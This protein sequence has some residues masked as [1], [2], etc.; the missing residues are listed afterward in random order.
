[1]YSYPPLCKLKVKDMAK[2]NTDTLTTQHLS[3]LQIGGR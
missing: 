1:M 3:S 2:Y